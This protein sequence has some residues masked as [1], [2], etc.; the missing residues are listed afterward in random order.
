MAEPTLAFHYTHLKQE[1]GQFLGWKRDPAGWSAEQATAIDL[2]VQAGY[3]RFLFPPLLPGQKEMHVWSFLSPLSTFD[4]APT[5]QDYDAPDDF[6]GLIGRPTILTVGNQY[7]PL[8]VRGEGQ[9]RA[10]YSGT[11][12][13]GHPKMIAVRPKECDGTTGQRWEFIIWPEPNAVYTIQYRRNRLLDALTDARP[14]PV[15]GMA[16]GETILES[17]L[18]IAE[19]RE[20]DSP[21]VHEAAFMARLE[22][23]E[24]QDRQLAAPQVLG[25]NADPSE[26]QVMWVRA[27]YSTYNGVVPS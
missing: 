25:Y 16:H 22:S 6:A 4:T 11:V 1:V 15:G 18:G 8:D 12:S 24:S 23:S 7:P 26:A 17:S 27:P 13:T 5:D 14:Y 10:L 9:L 2:I 3:R 19:Q 20:E 21:G